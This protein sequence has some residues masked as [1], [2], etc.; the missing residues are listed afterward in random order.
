VRNAANDNI[1]LNLRPLTARINPLPDLPG[2]I[3]LSFSVGS[4]IGISQ[5][6]AW[7]RKVVSGYYQYRAVPGN[8]NRLRTFQQRINRL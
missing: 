3:Q 1:D 4:M 6:G 7:L 2:Q 8:I 5:V